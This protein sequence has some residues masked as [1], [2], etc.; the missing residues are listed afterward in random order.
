MP[1]SS[2]AAEDELLATDASWNT[3][4]LSADVA[5]LD[6]LLADDWL[7]THSDGKVQ[8]RAEY[9]EELSTRSRRNQ[10]IGNED[11]RLRRYGDTAVVTGTSVQSAVSNGQPWQGRFRFTRVWV[12]RDGH[13][14]MVASHS[15]RIPE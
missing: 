12:Q 11:V 15:S 6:R 2:W 4:R 9:L 1:R 14:V 3:L 5:G 10:A 7:L 8:A 13:W